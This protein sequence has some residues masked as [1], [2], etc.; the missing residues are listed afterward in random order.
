MLK[1]SPGSL[2]PI[3]ETLASAVPVRRDPALTP[4]DIFAQLAKMGMETINRMPGDEKGYH[5]EKCRNKGYLFRLREDNS[6]YTVDCECKAMRKCFHEMAQSGMQNI[7][8]RYTFANFL[9]REPWQQLLLDTAKAYAAEPEGWLLV[10]GQSGGGKTHICAAVCRKL[11][12]KGYQVRYMFWRDTFEKLKF[13]GKDPQQQEEL[14]D[15]YRN[16]Q[17]LYIDDLFKNGDRNNV[18][19]TRAEIGFAFELINH[20]YTNGLMTIIST[21]RTTQQLLT[22]DQAT[23]GRIVEMSGRNVIDLGIDHTK[24]QRLKH[25]SK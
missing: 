8:N 13:V 17:V 12:L 3:S 22:V 7:L 11:L 2:A 24:N 20:R 5:C 10:C 14:K 21:E 19:P 6:R 16:A 1:S 15:K 23:G 18:I 25:W 4:Q 9:V